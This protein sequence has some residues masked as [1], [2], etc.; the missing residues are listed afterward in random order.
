MKT[1]FS[2][3]CACGAIR[4]ECTAEPVRMGQCHCRDCQRSS[5]G[6]FV[7]VV[8]VPGDSLKLLNGSPRYF[9][10][11]SE[12]GGFIHRGFCPDCGS[13]VLSKFDA[14]PHLVGIRAG[15]LDDP[16]WFR[17]GYDIW[18]SD[19][20]P[21]DHMNPTLTKYEKYPPFAHQAKPS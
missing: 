14:A 19:A 15:S 6:A 12:R 18:T 3:G 13:P 16:S 4:Y 8:V 5:G 21:W 1:P 20:Q 2:G 17:P 7:A 10:T 9:D 11:P